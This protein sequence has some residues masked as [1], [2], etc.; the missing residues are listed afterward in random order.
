MLKLLAVMILRATLLTRVAICSPPEAF[1][2]L[3][4]QIDTAGNHTRSGI[5]G[6]TFVLQVS[7]N[8]KN[9]EDIF[10]DNFRVFSLMCVFLYYAT[11][12]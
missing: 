11:V 7:S 3:V 6:V 4:Q 8:D 10:L 9:R 1:D 2:T 12:C 5:L